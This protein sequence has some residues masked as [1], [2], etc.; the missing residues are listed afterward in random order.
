MDKVLEVQRDIK[1]NSEDIQDYLRELNSWTQDIKK[2]DEQLSQSNVAKNSENYPPVRSG[3]IETVSSKSSKD[4]ATTRKGSEKLN[5]ADEPPS[6][7][8]KMKEA[9]P[10]KKNR[11]KSYDYDKWS[12][13]DVDAACKEVD[14]TNTKGDSESEECEDSDEAEMIENERL[15]QEAIAE[16]ERGNQFFKAGK[17]DQAIE[18]YTAGMGCDPTNAMLPANRAMALLKK[19]QYGA[20]E[21][22]AS[23]AIDLDKTYV[24]AY[25]RRAS[26]KI[27]LGKIEDAI[28]DYDEVLK[29]EPLNKA[30][31]VEKEKLLE[32][33]KDR[34]SAMSEVDSKKLEVQDSKKNNK[35][36]EKTVKLE[37]GPKSTRIVIQEEEED[38]DPSSVFPISKL[39][40]Q[41]SKKPLRRIEITE[42]GCEDED[43]PRNDHESILTQVRDMEIE[44]SDKIDT[45]VTD[46]QQSKSKG[47]A[48]KVEQEI[49]EELFKKSTVE[50]SE[51]SPAPPI[52]PFIPKGSAQ[53][54][55]DW[56]K[57]KTV[58]QRVKYID[59]FH[60]ST[61]KTVF[62]N[63]MEAKH[64][65]EIVAVLAAGVKSEIWRKDEIAGHLRG[66]SQVPRI[67]ALA[68]FM[69]KKDQKTLRYRCALAAS[70][71]SVSEEESK[72]WGR[73]FGL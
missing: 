69:D 2:K 66:L 18:K 56:T 27:G 53:F 54:L 26:A 16:K 60:E 64:F 57:C 38:I 62:K 39:P 17:W 36:D 41:R 44:T 34:K 46:K 45:D 19:E 33:L 3:K 49:A 35:K 61:Y 40:H 23:M 28:K 67:S 32:V 71:D 72:S 9:A 68:M 70:R 24:K 1:H 51:S 50:Q 12:K 58:D 22:D 55:M 8:S 6:K 47:F 21:R 48:K 43:K 5:L 30:A 73:T 42:I 31:K 52:V 11:I 13:F 37:S 65:S 10:V 4:K 15:K 14:E 63:S 25:Q 7:T 29:L 59:Q 20:A